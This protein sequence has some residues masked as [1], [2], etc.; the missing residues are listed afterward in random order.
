MDIDVNTSKFIGYAIL[1]TAPVND[2]RE[3]VPVQQRAE[4]KSLVGTASL[5][6]SSNSSIL[7]SKNFGGTG[8]VS[9]SKS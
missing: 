3:S 8:F 1:E 2:D 7:A 6:F 9:T 5:S 4:E